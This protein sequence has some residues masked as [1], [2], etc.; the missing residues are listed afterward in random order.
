MALPLVRRP[1]SQSPPPLSASFFPSVILI[2][3]LSPPAVLQDSLG[4]E[5]RKFPHTAYVATGSSPSAYALPI[6]RATDV[7]ISSVSTGTQADSEANNEV[8]VMK[9]GGMHR[10]QHDDGERHFLAYLL[11]C[12]L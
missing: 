11:L 2:V 3:S 1:P 6:R 9:M 12:C 7:L 10:T 8:L 5:R 4:D